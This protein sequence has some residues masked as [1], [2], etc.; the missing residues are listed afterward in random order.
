[1]QRPTKADGP[2]EYIVSVAYTL[3]VQG[4]AKLDH[5][6]EIMRATCM[7][8]VANRHDRLT[9]LHL[10]LYCG[11]DYKAERAFAAQ[12]PENALANAESY[13]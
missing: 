13:R 7:R 5:Q 11:V 8:D 1:V 3:S 2:E 12:K 9:Q 10:M 6:P 4:A